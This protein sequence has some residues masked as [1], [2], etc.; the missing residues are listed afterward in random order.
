MLR[1]NGNNQDLFNV[2]EVKSPFFPPGGSR[3]DSEH[4]IRPALPYFGHQLSKRQ[5][6]F[7]IISVLTFKRNQ[8]SLN[9]I[10]IFFIW[11]APDMEFVQKFTPPDFKV[12]ILHCQ[13]HLI[14]TVLVGK[15]T[16][17]E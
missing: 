17:N 4:G 5:C 10:L 3:D 13:F 1:L 12:K 2:G 7:D 6:G 8:E 16:K 14:S 15:N 9:L 11:Q